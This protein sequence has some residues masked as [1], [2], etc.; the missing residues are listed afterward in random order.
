MQDYSQIKD[1]LSSEEIESLAKRVRNIELVS[2]G[3]VVP[4]IARNCGDYQVYAALYSF[5]LSFTLAVLLYLFVPLYASLPLLFYIQAFSFVFF[6]FVF[7]LPTFLRYLV[8]QKE[9]KRRTYRRA[10]QAFYNYDLTKS[11]S[12]SAVLIFISLFERQIHVLCDEGIKAV[13]EGNCWKDIVL[14][15]RKELKKGSIFKAFDL[16][17][18]RCEEYLVEH[19]PAQN[20]S[21]NEV[22]DALLVL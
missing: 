22:S 17:F 6:F 7:R 18:D 16:A 14:L 19:F 21:Q 4:A 8:P 15:I 9:L 10:L 3:E 2:T 13:V 1:L 20:K 5:A 11:E 12:R